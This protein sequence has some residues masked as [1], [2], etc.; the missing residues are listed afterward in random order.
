[1]KTLIEPSREVRV[2]REVDVLVC[3]GGCAGAVAAITNQE[4]KRIRKI[5]FFMWIISPIS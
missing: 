5:A 1:M 2:R 4:A 3:G